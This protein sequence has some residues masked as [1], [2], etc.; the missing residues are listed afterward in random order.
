MTLHYQRSS[1]FE[2]IEQNKRRLAFLLNTKTSYLLDHFLNGK[3]TNVTVF[4]LRLL[5]QWL[6]SYISMHIHNCA[7]NYPWDSLFQCHTKKGSYLHVSRTNVNFTTGFFMFGYVIFS[8]FG[9]YA[10]SIDWYPSFNVHV[11]KYHWNQSF[12]I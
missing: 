4:P 9:Q 12:W 11:N 10:F 1:W 7:E 3:L 2:H 6:S 5:W 8:S